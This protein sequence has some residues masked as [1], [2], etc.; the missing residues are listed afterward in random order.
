MPAVGPQERLRGGDR[1][2]F[3]GIVDS[4]VDLQ[5]IRG[6]VP[7]TD[8]V[9]KLDSPRAERC[10]I[11][12]V[13]SSS[14]P[15]VGKTIRDGRFRSMYNAVVI[16]VARHGE[17]IHSKIGDIVLRAGD[18]LLLEAHSSFIAQQR[19]SRHFFLVSRLENSTPPRHEKAALALTIVLAM[20]V[21]VTFAENWGPLTIPLGSWS[22][23]LGEITMFKASL[24]A[25]ALM[26]LLRCCRMEEARRAIDWQVLIA[27]AASFGI[28]R[29]LEKS[30]A[31]DALTN[32]LIGASGGNAWLTLAV[33]YGVTLLITE[34]ITNNAAAALMFPFAISAAA[35]L[36]AN[37]VSFIIA[38]MMAA[39]A[40]FATPIGYQTN[41]MVYGPG[42]Y[43]F[44][45][46]LRVGVPL[47]LLVWAVTVAIAPLV[48]PFY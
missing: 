28:G 42:G 27:I 20:V 11:E 33:L 44:S 32:S 31:A 9:F 25:A 4:V 40:G 34:L 8:Q 36:G 39:S 21:V 38:V 45:D 2:V 48:W 13:T 24:V 37:P 7:A 46:Y 10:L 16:A 26:V 43:R 29:A 47:D 35:N 6:L 22:L 18:T 23:R 12:A 41:L 3:V 15:V 14:C 1:L 5:K 17:R 30:G 19:N